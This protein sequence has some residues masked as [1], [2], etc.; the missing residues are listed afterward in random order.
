M[1]HDLDHHA[2]ATVAAADAAASECYAAG[3]TNIF[4][5]SNCTR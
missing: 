3:L 2:A 1:A 5:N 4:S